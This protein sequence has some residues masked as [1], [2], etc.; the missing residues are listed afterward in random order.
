MTLSGG[1][2]L[3]ERCVARRAKRVFISVALATT[4]F[5]TAASARDL[6]D[7]IPPQ[8]LADALEAFAAASGYQLVYR[9]D[10]AAG[11]ASRGSD[12]H[13]PALDALEQ[14]LRGTG[15]AFNFVNDHTIAIIKSPPDSPKAPSARPLNQAPA[16][17]RDTG[18]NLKSKEGVLA[19][20]AA[21]FQGCTS[22]QAAPGCDGQP[23]GGVQTARADTSM[24]EIIVT[25]T[26]QG[27]M[28]AAESPVPIQMI[29]RNA[30][31]LAASG[32][33]LMSTLAQL[34]PS[35]TM[36]AYGVDMAAQTLQAKLRG[37][38]PNHVL[39]LIDGKR[40]HTTANI[41][42]AAGSAYQGGAGV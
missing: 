2:V 38:N 14:L 26:R 31:Q 10:L 3:R 16:V 17:D 8:P 33:D 27:A 25:G 19:R 34:I 20:L 37:L 28:Q 39:V 24:A 6:P 15:L 22:A 21:L 41:A 32:A 36:Q 42:V 4:L 30:L 40:R 12:A 35:M 1:N 9:T 29:S 18:G 11:S 13:L 23:S 7:A 5:C